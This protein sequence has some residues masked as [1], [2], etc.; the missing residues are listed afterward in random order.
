MKYNTQKSKRKDMPPFAFYHPLD[1]SE[2]DPS[3]QR[4]IIGKNPTRT[5]SPSLGVDDKT[6]KRKTRK[7]CCCGRKEMVQSKTGLAL[8]NLCESRIGC[9]KQGVLRYKVV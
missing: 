8:V 6:R 1:S 9:V 3:V 7:M 2:I 4:I 5:S